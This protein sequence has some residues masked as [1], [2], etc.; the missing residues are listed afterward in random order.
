MLLIAVGYRACG[1]HLPGR[2]ELNDSMLLY[3][4]ISVLLLLITSSR[5]LV[6]SSLSIV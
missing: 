1:F 6:M 3:A 2:C 5:L 4:T